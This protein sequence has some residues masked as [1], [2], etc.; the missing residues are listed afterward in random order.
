V[1]AP[2]RREAVALIAGAIAL[3]VVGPF[4]LAACRHPGH[5]VRCSDLFPCCS[6]ASPLYTDTF[7]RHCARDVNGFFETH[8]EDEIPC[9]SIRTDEAANTF[10]HDLCNQPS[11][12]CPD[13]RLQS[14]GLQCDCEP[15]GKR[16][17]ICRYEQYDD[18]SC[19]LPPP[20][21]PPM[22][23]MMMMCPA[24][25]FRPTPASTCKPAALCYSDSP[26]ISS[27]TG[28]LALCKDGY[29][30]GG[31]SAN[32]STVPSCTKVCA[33]KAGTCMAA[34]GC[35]SGG[36]SANPGGISDGTFKHDPG[37]DVVCVCA[38]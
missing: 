20:G 5:G 16:K 1:A 3:A 28:V 19:A 30:A 27:K 29:V 25:S 8:P 24:A 38:D 33:P 35:S 6:P 4:V 21:P 22:S 9:N 7:P 10:C 11:C 2:R 26:T 14:S 15:K 32:V 13:A 37:S 17:C 34:P 12:I 23:M 18:G 36:P 31:F